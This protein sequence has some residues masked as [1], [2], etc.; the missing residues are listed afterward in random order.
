MGLIIDTR[1]GTH[2]QVHPLVQHPLA[3]EL[4]QQAGGRDAEGGVGRGSPSARHVVEEV[5]PQLAEQ[6]RAAQQGQ[7]GA[8]LERDGIGDVGHIGI[9]A[10]LKGL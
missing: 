7:R 10:A 2:P 1:G 5:V 3:V 6:R 4:T 9:T 8:G